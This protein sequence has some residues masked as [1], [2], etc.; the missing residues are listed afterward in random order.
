MANLEYVLQSVYFVLLW[1]C[2]ASLYLP[3]RFRMPLSLVHPAANMVDESEL[4]EPTLEYYGSDERTHTLSQTKQRNAEN[5]LRAALQK[6]KLSK[7]SVKTPRRS[8]HHRVAK[9][10]EHELVMS[11]FQVN[12]NG[13]MKRNFVVL[14]NNQRHIV[15]T[16]EPKTKIHMWWG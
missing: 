13:K 1:Q 12:E 10:T 3:S 7:N 9:D 14:K 16:P 5:L 6:N 15:S 8:P 4:Y 2:T 11:S